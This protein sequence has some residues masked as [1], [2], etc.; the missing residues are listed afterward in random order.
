[1]TAN[2]IVIGDVKSPLLSFDNPQLIQLPEVAS[3]ALI[4]E[5]LAIDEAQPTVE[6]EI[7]IDYNFISKDNYYIRSSDGLIFKPFSNY[8]LRRLPYATKVTLYRDDR[9]YAVFYSKNVKRVG[10]TKFEIN[11]I[12]AIGLMAKQPHAG[13]IYTGEKFVDVLKEILG[14]E[15]SYTITDDAASVSVYGWLPYATRRE[16]LHQ[17]LIASGVNVLR[18][19]NGEMLFAVLGNAEP[20]EIPDGRIYIDGDVDFTEP[21]SR[22]VL[23]EHAF[24]YLENALEE[25][26]F[27]NT[28]SDAV[29][30]AL[31]TFKQ[32]IYPDSLRCSEGTLE[33]LETAVNYAVV[34]GIGVLQGKPYTHTTRSMSREN[35]EAVVENEKKLEDAT[36]VTVSNSDN[37][38]LRLAEYYFNTSRIRANIEV[39]GE[40]PGRRYVFNNAFNERVTGFVSSMDAVSSNI[41]KAECEIITNYV[42]KGQGAAYTDLVILPAASGTW[43]IPQKVFEKPV[44][45]IRVVL[46]G[47]GSPGTAGTRGENGKAAEGENGT[48]TM[49]AK[50]TPGEGGLGGEGGSGGTGGKIYSITMDCTGIESFAYG[51]SGQ[52]SYFKGGG[53]DLSSA[54]GAVN[55]NGFLEVF[56]GTVYALP[57][58]VGQPGSQGGKGGLYLHSKYEKKIKPATDG[59]AKTYNGATYSG[60]LPGDT[61]SK[62]TTYGVNYYYYGGGGGG[63]ASVK[64]KGGN[65]HGFAEKDCLGG[66][67]A[68]GA[69]G[70]AAPALYGAGGNGG[71]G[72]GGGGGGGIRAVIN[73]S[74]SHDIPVHWTG[75]DAYSGGTGGVGGAGSAGY[76]GCVLIY[77]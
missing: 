29:D 63:G 23:T 54:N 36:L 48:T 58:H 34:S 25:I 17:L 56:S 41:K 60:G 32:P 65:G 50:G 53:Y 10:K 51:R 49:T 15:Y 55:E 66:A 24:F 8:D 4:G 19:D 31:V 30:K 22:V 42:P 77:L 3:I 43:Q 5:E 18:A 67:G 70:D 74:D 11:C 64:S 20:T 6:Y 27:D 14:G 40:R 2:R 21:A 52:D 37:V 47:S 13:G 73:I 71:N 7:F 26:L 12:S 46:I 61:G 45:N 68:A 57:G 1:M 28:R 59:E 72:G 44:P 62:W 33:I 38:L 75:A 16:N 9:P 39:D 35:S 76:Q 69:A